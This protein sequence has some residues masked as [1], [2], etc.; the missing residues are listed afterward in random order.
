MTKSQGEKPTSDKIKE[1]LVTP[2]KS[3]PVVTVPGGSGQTDE[4]TANHTEFPLNP[5]SSVFIP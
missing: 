4:G 2:R 3:K 1:K 5:L